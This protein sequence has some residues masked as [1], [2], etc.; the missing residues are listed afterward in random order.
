MSDCKS[1]REKYLEMAQEVEDLDKKSQDI[2]TQIADLRDKQEALFQTLLEE[3][4]LLEGTEWSLQ[5]LN[6]KARLFTHVNRS[7]K[8]NSGDTTDDKLNTISNLLRASWHSFYEITDDISIQFN[9]NEV[10][11]DFTEVRLILPFVTK[12]KMVVD[13][14]KFVDELRKARRQ[15]SQL[16]KMAHQLGIKE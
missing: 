14:S 15:T 8:P 13:T 3:E 4:K 5:F 6:G 10:E 1:A 11:I 12:H 16:E 7:A 9:D 2:S